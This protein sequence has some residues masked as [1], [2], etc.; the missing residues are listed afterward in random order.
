MT[1][2]LTTLANDCLPSGDTLRTIAM[3]SILGV[4]IYAV[5]RDR[6]VKTLRE[7]V[8]ALEQRQE[9]LEKRLRTVE[10]ALKT[11]GCA[12]ARDCKDYVPYLDSAGIEALREEAVT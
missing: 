4:V 1:E 7:S 2:W 3:M 10:H 9:A 6:A 12:F 5:M 11:Y 8:S